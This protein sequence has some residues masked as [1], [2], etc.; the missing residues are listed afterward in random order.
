MLFTAVAATETARLSVPGT[1]V[2]AVN[3]LTGARTPSSK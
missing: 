2:G 1:S 3:V